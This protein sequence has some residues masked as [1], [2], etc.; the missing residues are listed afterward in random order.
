[1]ALN[2][3]VPVMGIRTED[4]PRVNSGLASILGDLFSGRGELDTKGNPVL[5]VVWKELPKGFR[6][7]LRL[8]VSGDQV[9][10]E[11]PDLGWLVN[12]RGYL[13]GGGRKPQEDAGLAA[14][15][16]RLFEPLLERGE[17]LQMDMIEH[18]VSD[19]P[20]GA[21]FLSPLQ[22]LFS[23]KGYINLPNLMHGNVS[24]LIATFGFSTVL[25]A[26]HKMGVVGEEI[27]AQEEMENNEVTAVQ[28]TVD[29]N[30]NFVFEIAAGDTRRE[31]R[32][33][34]VCQYRAERHFE[35]NSTLDSST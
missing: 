26:A 12:L 7:S 19:L 6:D 22:Y 4:V 29:G 13:T 24:E 3:V 21:G 35:Y 27:G 5:T 28:L 14:F 8:S 23:S 2:L 1:M 30:V 31:S 34:I 32:G 11:V 18:A 9:R 20:S 16:A 10:S 17:R 25:Y 15:I 33:F